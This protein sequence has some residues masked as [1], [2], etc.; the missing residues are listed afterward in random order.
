MSGF[1][2]K[3]LVAETGAPSASA[4]KLSVIQGLRAV[5]ALLV[6]WTHSIDAAGPY[7]RSW[8]GRFF[9]LG[10]FGACGLDIF[11]VISGFI[12]SLVAARA[13]EKGHHSA[14]TFLTRRFT[15]IYPIY[16]ILT[17]VI[18]LEA[19]V[20]RHPIVW[21]SVA[22]LPTAGLMPSF[23]YPA[24][25]PVLSLGWSLIFEM[26]FY[27]V[28]TAWLAIQPAKLVRNTVLFLAA[29]VAIGAVVSFQ[30]PLLIVWANPILLEFLFGCLIGQIYGQRRFDRKT[31]NKQ[32][33]SR[34]KASLLGRWIAVAGAAWLL[35]TLF[36]G[37]GAINFQGMVLNGLSSWQRVGLWGV[38]SGLLV[39]G[40]ILWS[41]AM[42]SWPARLLVFLG[43]ASYSIYLCTV[44]ARSMV[45]HFWKFFAKEG[46]DVAIL[47]CALVCVLT[48][49]IC[50]LLLERPLMRLFHNWYKPVPALRKR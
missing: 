4:G 25:A 5:A 31:E 22:W 32:V 2:D 34:K 14:R 46:S 30:R 37:Y 47:L 43:D 8:Q 27:L 23:S 49:V 12:V 39:L 35:E 9:H 33:S 48:G 38:P 3:T 50:Y 6:V 7:R 16:W 29:M 26:Y 41:P 42:Q 36:T 15:R 28:L 40:S 24:A 21:S 1:V 11:F 45:E 18:I 13:A 17:L 19:Q 44:P 10:G 20:G